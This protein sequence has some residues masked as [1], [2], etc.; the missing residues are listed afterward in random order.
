MLHAAFPLF[1]GAGI[2]RAASASFK[3]FSQYALSSST[4]VFGELTLEL[5]LVGPANLMVKTLVELACGRR[6][7]KFPYE[8]RQGFLPARR[9]L[10]VVNALVNYG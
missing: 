9:G 8:C 7:S 6:K 1:C 10:V 5:L 3:N 4:L 2:C